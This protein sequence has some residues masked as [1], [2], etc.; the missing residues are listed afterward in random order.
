MSGTFDPQDEQTMHQATRVQELTI[1]GLDYA[2]YTTAP[3]T[4]G[5]T[6]NVNIFVNEPVSKVYNAY[7][8]IDASNT[9]QDFD[10][11]EIVIT[12]SNLLTIS[13]N[14]AATPTIVTTTTP[15][16]LYTGEQVTISGSNS[17]PSLNGVQAV[18]VVTPYTFA[19]PLNVTVAGTA[20]SIDADSPPNDYGCIQLLGLS[21][22]SFHA[23]DCIVVKY[24]TKPSK[25]YAQ[26]LPTYNQ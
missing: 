5:G 15:H 1:C 9:I 6:I 26:S 11:A 8:K 4:A 16:M 21:E 24:T 3:G 25:F 10:Q 2:M 23:N 14:T 22:T 7:A 13:G 17:T 18:T 12:D 20:G 19:L